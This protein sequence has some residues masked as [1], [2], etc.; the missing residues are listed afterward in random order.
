MLKSLICTALLALA[1]AQEDCPAFGDWRDWTD[2][3]VWFP[4][5]NLRQSFVD[6][7]DVKVDL[8]AMPEM[9]QIPDI[10]DKC[11]HC[12]NKFRCRKREK[13]DGCF[14]LDGEKKVCS[15]HSDV[16]DM[17][18]FPLHNLGCRYE[19]APMYLQQCANRP[20]LPDWKRDGLKKMSDMLPKFHCKDKDGQCKCC[21][22]PFM[23]NE[24]ASEC[25]QHNEPECEAYSEWTD[26]SEQC[27]WW[28]PADIKQ[29][30]VDH[31]GF[32]MKNK[33]AD[34]MLSKLKLPE[35]VEIPDRCGFCSFKFKCRKRPVE[36][37]E[38]KKHCFPL[39]MEKKACGT[40]DCP[41]CGNVCEMP[42]FA[43]SCNYTDQIRKMVG[44]GL[45]GRMKKMPHAMQMG[46][47]K[48]VSHMPHGKCVE[49]GDKC[50]CCC[51]PY[52]PN[53]EGTECVLK[54]VCKNAEDMGLEVDLNLPG[55]DAW[56]W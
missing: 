2:E 44:P 13:Q 50:H 15:E 19:F 28:P 17:P 48:M 6:A 35:G 26:W 36:S 31:C 56:W 54:D 20:D 52:E 32:D 8:S 1:A 46:M 5:D 39:D 38:G 21:C 34:S 29:Q 24:D 16:C 51:H 53:E 9:P 30:F 40:D 55:D 12:S 49:K 43:G 41:T 10:P 25:I 11:G 33:K 7:C 27:V 45:R 14:P 23:P 18:K 37:T 47:M 3:C 42:K 4:L 22:H